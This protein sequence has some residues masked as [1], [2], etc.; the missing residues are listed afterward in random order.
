MAEKLAMRP[1][2][3]PPSPGPGVQTGSPVT[4]GRVGITA[5]PHSFLPSI[6]VST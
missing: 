2:A 4:Q 3:S 6:Q 1:E 5:L